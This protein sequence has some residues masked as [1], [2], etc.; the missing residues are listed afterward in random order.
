MFISVAKLGIL[1][2]GSDMGITWS[3]PGLLGLLVPVPST[4]SLVGPVLSDLCTTMM[5]C[6][7]KE[8]CVRRP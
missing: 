7:T 8:G 3:Q 5:C 2:G 4:S 6:D 1:I